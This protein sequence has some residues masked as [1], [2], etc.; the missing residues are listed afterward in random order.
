MRIL[1]LQIN[2]NNRTW[3]QAHVMRKAGHVPSLAYVKNPVSHNFPGLPDTIFE[4]CVKMNKMRGAEWVKEQLTRNKYDVVHSHNDQLTVWALEANVCPVVGDIHDMASL[5]N[6]DSVILDLER[7]AIRM[8][9]VVIAATEGIAR[10]V[11]EKYDVEAEVIHNYPFEEQVVK[12]EFPK[13]SE[14]G[15]GP[16]CVYAG[17]LNRK[18]RNFAL[19]ATATC[20]RLASSSDQ[21]SLTVRPQVRS[22]RR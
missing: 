6:E 20:E 7:N 3:K 22:R 2:A 19:T 21:P 4:E 13:L 16:C 9:D 10:H 12:S 8:T 15:K 11:G 18:H 1:H 14:D 17:R 5:T